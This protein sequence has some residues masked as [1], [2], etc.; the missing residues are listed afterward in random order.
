MDK[1]LRVL[2]VDDEEIVRETIKRILKKE[3]VTVHTAECGNSAIALVKTEELDVALL[4]IKLPG[5]DG[6]DTLIQLKAVKPKISVVMMT[7]YEVTERIEKAFEEGALAC[8]HKP[9]DIKVLLD[10]FNELK[11]KNETE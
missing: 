5:I 4:D 11:E 2:V 8:L 3:G 1:P 7:G 9:F 6:V 10:I